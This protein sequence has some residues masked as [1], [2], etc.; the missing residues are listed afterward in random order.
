MPKLL[1]ALVAALALAAAPA[2]ALMTID[3]PFSGSSL[4]D[5]GSFSEGLD[6]N[7]PGANAGLSATLMSSNLGGYG[8]AD[9][10]FSITGPG[11]FLLTDS[12]PGA[13]AGSFTIL[14]GLHAGSLAAGTYLLTV[15]GTA[16]GASGGAY[17]FSF[18]ALQALP[19]PE[20][21]AWALIAAGLAFMAFVARRRARA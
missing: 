11:G 19:V 17:G 18:A 4:V 1:R 2:H 20:P 10:A 14:S 6:I 5:A 16:T 9:F 13:A 7:V 12:A 8:I 3:L 15:T 21:G